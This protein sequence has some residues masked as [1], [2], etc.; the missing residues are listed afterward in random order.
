MSERTDRDFLEHI[1]EAAGRATFY[2][3][4]LTFEV[5]LE[6]T[7]TQDAVIRNIEVI[8][9]AT[10]NL[11]DELRNRHTAIPWK[12]LA[13]MRDRLIH[14][15]FGVNLD[16][17]WNVAKKELPEMLSEIKKIIETEESDART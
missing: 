3:Q 8:G 15:Y 9:E 5:F 2:T 1:R 10:K 11:S 7:K 13:G 14:R 16:I 17:V 12:S 6:D 4:K